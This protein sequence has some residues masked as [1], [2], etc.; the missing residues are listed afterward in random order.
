[1]NKYLKLV[2][3]DRF[4]VYKQFFEKMAQMPDWELQSLK[5]VC[6]SDFSVFKEVAKNLV[7]ETETSTAA[8]A[9]GNVFAPIDA[10]PEEWAPGIPRPL[11]VPVEA[12]PAPPPVADPQEDTIVMLMDLGFSRDIVL[13]ALENTRN[14]DE[15]ANYLLAHGNDVRLIK[16]YS[17]KIYDRFSDTYPGSCQCLP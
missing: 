13:Y 12:Q 1:M 17:L 14:P 10:P 16:T 3:R 6:E 7:E 8:A 2:C 15:A 11:Q 5:K 9:P 4:T